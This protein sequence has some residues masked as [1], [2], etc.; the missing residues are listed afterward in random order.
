[1][2]WRSEIADMLLFTGILAAV[3]IFFV[4]AKYMTAADTTRKDRHKEQPANPL[5]WIVSI[6]AF[7]MFAIL[8]VLIDR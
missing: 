5:P 4:L 7:L 6:G 1:M 2:D 8:Y 3:I